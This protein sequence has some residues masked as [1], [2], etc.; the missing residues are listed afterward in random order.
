VLTASNSPGR[1]PHKRRYYDIPETSITPRP[2]QKPIPFYVASFSKT[3]LD[4]AAKRGLNI[5]Y[6]PFAAGM[7]FGGLDKAVDSYREACV[8]AG[9]QPG[10]AMCSYFIF[11][12]DDDKAEDYG[13]E[14]QMDYFRHCVIQAFP[15]KPEDAPPTMQYFLKIVDILKNM[16]KENLSDKSILIGRPEKIVESLKKVESAGIEE[17]IL[18]FNVGNKPN[19]LVKEQMHRFMKEIAPHFKGKHLERMKVAA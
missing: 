14:T 15:G 9:N 5:I 16:K 13:R 18:Y 17:V 11:I 6:A 2:V 19:S 1:W 12:A 4:M 10:R 8:K 3:S 7:V